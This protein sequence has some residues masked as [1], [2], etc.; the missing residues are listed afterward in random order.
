M[1]RSDSL[2]D[3]VYDLR[4]ALYA[5]HHFAGTKKEEFGVRYQDVLPSAGLGI[6][7]FDCI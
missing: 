2:E 7:A 5:L 3:Y 1:K 4:R 6:F